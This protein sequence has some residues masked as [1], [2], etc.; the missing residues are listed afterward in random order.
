MGHK[1]LTKNLQGLIV[2]QNI[3]CTMEH[4]EGHYQKVCAI[5]HDRV[6]LQNWKKGSKIKNLSWS[7]KT[8]IKVLKQHLASTGHSLHVRTISHS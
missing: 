2:F 1:D 8:T 7:P 3:S 5:T 6:S 4:F